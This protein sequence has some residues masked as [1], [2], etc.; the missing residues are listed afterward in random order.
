LSISRRQQL[1]DYLEQ[2][3]ATRKA[4]DFETSDA[5]CA[6]LRQQFG[7]RIYNDP[8]I[9]TTQKGAAPPSYLRKK[10][11]TAMGRLK[12]KHGPRGHSYRHVGETM[13]P[14]ICPL[15]WKDVHGLL[16]QLTL[17]REEGN[18]EKADAVEFELLINGIQYS[19][20]HKLWRADGVDEWEETLFL[21]NAP[22]ENQPDKDS[23]C[24]DYQEATP[25]IT[26]ESN[27]RCHENAVS[28][29]RVEQLI[30]QRTEAIVR[31]DEDLV[32]FLS[33]ELMRTY[34]VTVDD[35]QQTWSFLQTQE[36]DLKKDESPFLVGGAAKIPTSN[37]ATELV[38]PILFA[39]GVHTHWEASNAF[40]MSSKSRNVPDNLTLQ[41]IE[42]LVVERCQ[43]REEAKFLEADAI[44]KE[45]W[46]TYYVGINDRLRQWSIGGI[47]DDS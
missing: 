12:E 38:P 15:A 3:Y 19:D 5:I 43:K 44:R 46:L 17:A 10:Q 20:E 33:L 16:A 11:E 42:T 29:T 35:A 1:K 25:P 34:R 47:F 23:Q 21:T 4:R 40:R 18:Q 14:D 39:N 6:A 45:L 27:G 26:E 41:R 8:P 36:N 24:S 28:R 37:L 31:Q 30:R 9:W 22:D 32:R 7:V 2:L 13:D